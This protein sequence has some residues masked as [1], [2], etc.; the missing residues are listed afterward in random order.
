M[1]RVSSEDTKSS[2]SRFGEDKVRSPW[3]SRDIVTSKED[4]V[5]SS[6]ADMIENGDGPLREGEEALAI[7]N[8]L[9]KLHV[10]ISLGS[11]TNDN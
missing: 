10:G 1:S 3:L 2:G 8:R 7:V 5:Q 9:V 6:S 11:L 4:E